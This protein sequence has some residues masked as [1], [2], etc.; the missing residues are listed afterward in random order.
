PAAEVTG[1]RELV[2]AAAGFPLLV[3][4]VRADASAGEGVGG[5]AVGPRRIR[6]RIAGI[7]AALRSAG[8][9]RWPQ[10]F[11][12]EPRQVRTADL[13]ALVSGEIGDDFLVF[14]PLGEMP[15]AAPGARGHRACE[16]FV[17]A[18]THVL[19]RCQDIP[20]ARP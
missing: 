3:F 11:G 16:E 14:D 19:A 9:Q 5:P 20:A 1:G 10:R 6:R 15:D 17:V 18:L 2:L 12:S 4:G 13:L 8:V 7:T